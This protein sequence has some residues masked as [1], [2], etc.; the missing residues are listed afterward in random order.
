VI[1]GADLPAREV[2]L[3]GRTTSERLT[4]LVG[5]IVTESRESDHIRQSLEVGEAFLRLRKF[6]FTSV[7]LA[8]PASIESERARGSCSTYS[9][10][11]WPIRRR[12]P[13]DQNRI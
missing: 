4:R 3:L 1:Q 7:Y 13:R 5:D 6:M 8:P 10:G 9:S 11:F 2:A 12:S